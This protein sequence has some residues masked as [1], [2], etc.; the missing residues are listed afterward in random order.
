MRI[1][2]HLNS[3]RRKI[4]TSWTSQTRSTEPYWWPLSN[5]CK[6]VTVRK[7]LKYKSKTHYGL[8][9]F[10]LTWY[11]CICLKVTATPS[12]TDHLAVRRR[13]F[14]P[15]RVPSRRLTRLVIRA[16]TKAT[17]TW[18]TVMTAFLIRDSPALLFFISV[19]RCFFIS[20]CVRIFRTCRAARD[21]FFLLSLSCAFSSLICCQFVIIRSAFSGAEHLSPACAVTLL[22]VSLHFHWKQTV[23]RLR[24]KWVTVLRT[25]LSWSTVFTVTV[26]NSDHIHVYDRHLLWLRQTTVDK[27]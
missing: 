14:C 3:W 18:R 1:W 16:V 15:L 9:D 12:G 24:G 21:G 6:S 10:V 5:F 4:W 17:R 26:W 25:I 23:L 13:S 2:T 20:A 7:V 11:S 8:A 27:Q 22:W 19:T